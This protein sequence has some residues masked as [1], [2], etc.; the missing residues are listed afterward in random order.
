MGK[1]KGGTMKKEDALIFIEYI[2]NAPKR[3]QKHEQ[4]FLANVKKQ[5]EY[6]SYLSSE[7][8]LVIK[9]M[10]RRK[11]SFKKPAGELFKRKK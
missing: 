11:T 1:V 2:E 6:K 4:E 8:S 5:L 3:L 9:D 7:Q 10:Y